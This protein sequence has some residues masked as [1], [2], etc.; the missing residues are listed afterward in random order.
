MKHSGVS[1]NNC[2]PKTFYFLDLNTLAR[3]VGKPLTLAYHPFYSIS[4]DTAENTLT[5]SKC[6]YKNI[7]VK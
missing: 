1:P 6:F 3:L 5:Y 4:T 2:N 7:H